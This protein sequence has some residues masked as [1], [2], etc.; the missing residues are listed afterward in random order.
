MPAEQPNTATAAS[1]EPLAFSIDGACE[2]SG[3]GR[4]KIY[5]WIKTGRL[6]AKKA[7]GR[8][9][10]LAKDLKAFLKNLPDMPAKTA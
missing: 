8:T 1:P 4:T 2:A 7:D 10:I 6:R 5:K 3:S 9:L